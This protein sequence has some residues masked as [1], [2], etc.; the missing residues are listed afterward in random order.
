MKLVNCRGLILIALLALSACA[1]IPQDTSNSVTSPTKKTVSPPKPFNEKPGDITFNNAAADVMYEI[2]IGELATQRGNPNV[3]S[4]FYLDAAKQSKDPQIASRAVR[5]ANFAE[6]KDNAL[7][8][9]Q[10]WVE[11][12]PDNPE[13]IRILA[14]LYLREN[15]TAKA[16]ELLTKLLNDDKESISRNLL[17][18]GA[19]LQR[20]TSA[21]SAEKVAKHL[22]TL[23]P[24]EAESHYIHASLAI[25]SDMNEEALKS[26]EK[27]LAIR[28]N[29]VDAIILY[30]RILEENAQGEKALSFLKNYLNDNPKQ[31]SVRLAYAR[32]LTN[33]RNL[34]D[35]RSQFELLAVK[36][37]NNQDVLFALAMLSM[38]FKAY[39]EAEGYLMQLDKL[40]KTNSQVM[41]YLGQIAEQKDENDKAMRW[42]SNIRS[43]DFY[44]EAQLRISVILAK[45]QDVKKAQAHLHNIKTKNDNEKRQVLLFEGNLLRDFK[46]YQASFD[47]FSELLKENPKDAEYLYFR[48]LVAERLNKIDVVIE[49][50]SYVIENDPENAAALNALGYTLADKT[51]KL[52]EALKLI[53]RAWELEPEDPAIIDSLGWVNFKLGNHETALKLLSEAMEQFDDGEVSA[54]YGEV[55]W[56]TGNKDKAIKVWNQAKE[57]FG[58]NEVLLNTLK[59]FNQL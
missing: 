54:H 19:M 1:T 16:Q 5:I 29:W 2:L 11:A 58:D 34:E 49:D 4:D 52:N 25:Q 40:G 6:K 56:V 38:Q 55:L 48:S 30:P 31:D 12:E 32:S 41:F 9:A 18:T 24:N 15:E 27:S 23:F 46:E 33:N 21:E 3:A 20:E 22:T 7:E 36:M 42:Y 10:V 50:L 59:R 26:I 45:K 57:K 39:D 14:I 8:A 37:P 47:F 51:S 44:L 53:Q 28:P 17:L 13:A 43:D 35:A